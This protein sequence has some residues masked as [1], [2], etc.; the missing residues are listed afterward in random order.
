MSENADAP[1]GTEG[2]LVELADGSELEILFTPRRLRTMENVYSSIEQFM[3]ALRARPIQNIAWVVALHRTSRPGG[4][5]P[6]TR[7]VDAALDLV[8]SR[9]LRDYVRA[10]GGAVADG[11]GGGD[12]LAEFHRALSEIESLL[13]RL[14]PAE[15]VDWIRERI[16]ELRAAVPVPPQPPAAAAGGS[17]GGGTS[18]PPWSPSASTS[19]PSGTA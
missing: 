15:S 4:A 14:E 1:I 8:M 16:E 9:R 11:L 17:P 12:P 18:T 7:E 6:S 10:I 3:A 2:H 19:A 13:P 5:A